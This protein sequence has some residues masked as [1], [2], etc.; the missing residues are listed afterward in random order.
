[1]SAALRVRDVRKDSWTGSPG[2][3]CAPAIDWNEAKR[4]F[5]ELPPR[6][7]TEVP[8]NGTVLARAWQHCVETLGN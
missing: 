3:M 7:S 6:P 2:R 1:M 8:I 5:D 4:Q